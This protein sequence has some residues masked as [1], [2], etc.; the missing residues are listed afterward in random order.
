[1]RKDHLPS[2]D[3]F[4]DRGGFVSG[5]FALSIEYVSQYVWSLRLYKFGMV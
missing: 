1:M 5:L 2:S 4:I 3:N